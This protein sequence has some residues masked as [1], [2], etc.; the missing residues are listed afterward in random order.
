MPLEL[1]IARA[2]E[3]RIARNSVFFGVPFPS[4]MDLRTEISARNCH[5]STRNDG[6]LLFHFHK[7]RFLM[8]YIPFII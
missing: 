3:L 7:N 4:R 8:K 2:L 6:A 1:R 5:G